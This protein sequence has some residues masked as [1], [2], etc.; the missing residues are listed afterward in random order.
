MTHF[1]HRRSFVAGAA[2]FALCAGALVFGVLASLIV[3][4]PAVRAP[5]AAPRPAASLADESA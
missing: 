5:A 1:L 4:R 2:A 3:P